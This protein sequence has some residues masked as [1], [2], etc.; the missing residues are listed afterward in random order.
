[1]GL[2]CG[3]VCVGLPILYSLMWEEPTH[4]LTLGLALPKSKENKLSTEHA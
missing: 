3:H 1:M 2:A 4:S